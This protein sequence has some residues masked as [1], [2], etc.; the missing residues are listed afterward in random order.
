MI[1]QDIVNETQPHDDP[2]HSKGG[3]DTIFEQGCDNGEESV[4][5]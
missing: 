4:D 3:A 5:M 1:E 2:N